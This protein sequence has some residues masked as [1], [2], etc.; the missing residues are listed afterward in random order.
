MTAFA[1]HSKMIADSTHQTPGS[2]HH[3]CHPIKR[4]PFTALLANNGTSSD[5]SALGWQAQSTWQLNPNG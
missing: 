1:H 5:G 3:D 2:Q 4:H